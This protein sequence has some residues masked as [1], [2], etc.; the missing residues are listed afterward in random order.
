VQFRDLGAA[1]AGFTAAYTWQVT[2][3]YLTEP[4]AV[5]AA[6]L[7][8]GLVLFVTSVAVYVTAII[9][10]TQPQPTNRRA[11]RSAK[12]ARPPVAA[13]RPHRARQASTAEASAAV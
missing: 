8:S 3:K 6:L 10:R 12:Q 1:L 9:K 4:S 13:S 5:H 2:L 11:P 7:I